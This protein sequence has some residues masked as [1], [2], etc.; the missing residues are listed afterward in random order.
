MLNQTRSSNAQAEAIWPTCRMC[1]MQ[2]LALNCCVNIGDAASLVGLPS[3]KRLDLAWCREVSSSS[4]RSLGLPATLGSSLCRDLIVPGPRD[5][6]HSF[7]HLLKLSIEVA[8]CSCRWHCWCLI[9]SMPSS[10]GVKQSQMSCW[11]MLL[12]WSCWTVPSLQWAMLAFILLH[13]C[14]SSSM[15]LF[16]CRGTLDMCVQG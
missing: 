9:S 6:G 11:S 10:M 5:L 1:V 3:L 15:H 8:A 13:R 7:G 4:V 12:L 14:C 2:D 16:L